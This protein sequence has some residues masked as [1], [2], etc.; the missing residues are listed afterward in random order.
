MR[1]GRPVAALAA[2]AALS[3]GCGGA[4]GRPT[5]S[6]QLTIDSPTP[7]QVLSPDFTIKLNLV[8]ATVVPAGVVKGKL[9]GDQGHIHVSV[10]QQLISMA[11]ST[12]QDLHGIKPGRHSLQAEF[13]A[14]DHRPFK[15]RV[16][17]VTLFVVQ[18][19]GPT[20]SSP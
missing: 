9:R 11:Y 15:N 1:H 10:D 12:T 7:N 5:T 6:A 17:A 19:A 3:A 4:S 13:V 14:V 2:V 16:V 8:G 20:T 18:T